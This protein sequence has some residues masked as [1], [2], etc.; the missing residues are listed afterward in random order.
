MPTLLQPV[1]RVLGGL[2]EAHL[3]AFG[4]TYAKARRRAVP[5]Q[6]AYAL[7]TVVALVLAPAPTLRGPRREWACACEEEIAVRRAHRVLNR[8]SAA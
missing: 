3:D 5:P 4:K 1:R 6:R 8:P 7:A 2:V